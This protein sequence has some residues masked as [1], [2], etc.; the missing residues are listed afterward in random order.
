MITCRKE[1][2]PCDRNITFNYEERT[3][4]D[5]MTG[6]PLK[7]RLIKYAGFS[8]RAEL[9]NCPTPFRLVCLT[10]LSWFLLRKNWGFFWCEWDSCI[11][12]SIAKN[13]SVF[14]FSILS[15]SKRVTSIYLSHIGHRIVPPQNLGV[16]LKPFRKVLVQ[17]FSYWTPYR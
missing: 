7:V 10:N 17:S 12:T 13:T 2:T 8:L 15:S 11:P 16:T 6:A 5:W 3:R 14:Y 4:R 9:W 1:L